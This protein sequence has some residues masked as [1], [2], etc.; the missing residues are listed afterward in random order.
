MVNSEVKRSSWQDKVASEFSNVVLKSEP[1]WNDISS[2]MTQT[3]TKEEV[4]LLLQK[5]WCVFQQKEEIWLTKQ[6][7]LITFQKKLLQQLHK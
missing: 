2:I 1:K 3:L 4:L 5:I 6:E 7:Q